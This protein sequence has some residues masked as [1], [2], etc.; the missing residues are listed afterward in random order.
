M[1]TQPEALRLA[2]VLDNY[3]YADTDASAAK[4]RRLYAL[5]AEML[6]ALKRLLPLAEDSTTHPELN[7][8]ILD[9]RAAIA[10][11]TGEI[12]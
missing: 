12:Q 3:G 2:A 11:A 1:N 10:K 8:D 4:L 9:A 7:L 5:N 6:E